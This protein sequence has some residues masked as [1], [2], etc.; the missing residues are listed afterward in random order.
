MELAAIM[1]ALNAEAITTIVQN[2]ALTEVRLII[3]IAV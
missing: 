2:T 1:Y 3:F